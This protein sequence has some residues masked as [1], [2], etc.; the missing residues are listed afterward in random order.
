[1]LRSANQCVAYNFLIN[2]NYKIIYYKEFKNITEF[3]GL[4]HINKPLA[5]ILTFALLSLGGLPPFPGFITQHGRSPGGFALISPWR[6]AAFTLP[7]SFIWS[8]Q[9]HEPPRQETFAPSRRPPQGRAP[10]PGLA[11]GASAVTVKVAPSGWQ[12]RAAFCGLRLARAWL[13]SWRRSRWPWKLSWPGSSNLFCSNVD[14]SATR[15]TS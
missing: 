2:F 13:R 12:A 4:Y 9:H 8:P 3:A 5:L 7:N 11:G 1:M 14:S 6:F 10:V 15:P